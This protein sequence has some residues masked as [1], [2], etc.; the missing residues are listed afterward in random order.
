[1]YVAIRSYRN[2]RKCTAEHNIDTD[3]EHNVVFRG[4][5]SVG[6]SI[7]PCNIDRMRSPI[8]AIFLHCAESADLL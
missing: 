7:Y 1:M 6:L 4:I 8:I 3:G 2:F 5:S